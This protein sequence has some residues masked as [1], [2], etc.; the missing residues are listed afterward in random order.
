M[1]LGFRSFR[2]LGFSS[3]GLSQFRSSGFWVSE[4]ADYGLGGARVFTSLCVAAY[5]VEFSESFA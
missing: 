5:I 1:F 3:L 4:S 2:L